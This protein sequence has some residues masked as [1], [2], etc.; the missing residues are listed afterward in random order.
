MLWMRRLKRGPEMKKTVK[1][2]ITVCDICGK[3]AGYATTCRKCGLEVCYDCEEGHMVKYNHAV[4]FT[5]SG[6]GYYCNKCNTEL[7]DTGGDMLFN[8]YQ[9]IRRLREKERLFCV[10]FKAETDF[11]ETNIKI[12]LS[13]FKK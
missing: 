13:R 9:E 8:S 12:N 5:G 2:E 6:D 4:H 3:E 11:A 10:K 7:K 1:R